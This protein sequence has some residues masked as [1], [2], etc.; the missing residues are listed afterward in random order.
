VLVGG[1]RIVIDQLTCCHQVPSD[2]GSKFLGE[3]AQ[4]L[5][6][7]MVELASGDGLVDRWAVVPGLLDVA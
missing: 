1:L 5:G 3:A 6:D 4:L 7:G 2:T